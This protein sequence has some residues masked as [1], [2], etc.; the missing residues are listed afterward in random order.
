MLEAF[1]VAMAEFSGSKVTSCRYNWFCWLFVPRPTYEWFE[2]DFF[3][4]AA[5]VA[6]REDLE[7]FS[8]LSAVSA[9]PLYSGAQ[10][11]SHTTV[12]N[13]GFLLSMCSEFSVLGIYL[14]SF[15]WKSV[16]KICAK[17]ICPASVLHVNVICF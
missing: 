14:V 1:L 12:Y 6:S 13:A 3:Q 10:C 2:Q 16:C 5:N 4:R 15:S 17:Q 9:G 8:V 7:M 11:V